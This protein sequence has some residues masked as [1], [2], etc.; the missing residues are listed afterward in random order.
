MK[1]FISI[2]ATLSFLSLFVLGSAIAESFT[3]H[4]KVTFGMTLDEVTSY[5]KNAGFTVSAQKIEYGTPKVKVAK[6]VEGT[7]AGIDGSEI[8]YYFDKDNKLYSATYW[9]G[10]QLRST[11]TEYE[12]LEAALTKKYGASN[13]VYLPIVERIGFESNDYLSCWGLKRTNKTYPQYSSWLIQQD[14]GTYVAIVHYFESAT[15]MGT[16]LTFHI[17][18]YQVYSADEINAELDTI[19]NEIDQ[20]ND[21]I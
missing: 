6:K 19:S 18:G 21:D 5:E 10:S 7:I 12:T 9:L 1:K 13:E 2:L 8:H 11:L 16:K 3:L 4:S 20:R 17:L 15:V 14:D